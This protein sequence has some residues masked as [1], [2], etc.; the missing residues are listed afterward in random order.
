MFENAE[1]NTKD[2]LEYME[3]E[4]LQAIIELFENAEDNTND[5]LDI[6]SIIKEGEG[7]SA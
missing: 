7:R 5:T 4:L 2:M 1:A 3:G 6:V